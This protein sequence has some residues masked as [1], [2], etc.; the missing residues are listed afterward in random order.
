MP[1][2][3]PNPWCLASPE[4]QAEVLRLWAEGKRVRECGKAT[5]LPDGSVWNILRKAGIDPNLRP[6]PPS[7]RAQVEELLRKGIPV[8]EIASQLQ[9]SADYVR[10]CKRQLV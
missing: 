6:K 4:K 9:S 8:K 2:K 10:Q 7:K 5:G 1:A 3:W